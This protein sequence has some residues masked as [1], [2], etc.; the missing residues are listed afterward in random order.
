MQANEFPYAK[1]YESLTNVLARAYTQAALGKGADRHAGN[2][3]FDEQPM[4]SISDLLGSNVGLL[5]QAMKKI[6]ESQR[7]DKDAAIRELLGAI[8]YIAG[9]I[10]NMEKHQAELPLFTPQVKMGF[11]Q[12]DTMP[13]NM[14]I[15]SKEASIKPARVCCSRLVPIGEACPSCFNLK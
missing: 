1:G 8:N 14:I 11:A 4:Q 15:G 10:I 3:P 6:Q 2:R 12:H 9:A 7:L 13:G 5:Y